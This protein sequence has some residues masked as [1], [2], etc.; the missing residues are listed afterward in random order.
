VQSVVPGGASWRQGD[1][2]AGDLI[3]AVAQEGKE[4][5]DVADMPIDE[6]VQMIRGKKGTVVTLSVRKG[7]GETKTISITRDVVVI[8]D[9]YARG[10]VVTPKGIKASYGYIYLPGF[11]G[12]Q[13][14]GQRGAAS[15]M[16]RLLVELSKRKVDGV[17]IDLRGNG[18]GL[19][20]DAR[21]MTGLLIDKGPVVQTQ[22]GDGE[23]EVLSDDDAGTAFDGPVVVMVDRFSASASEI[24]AGALQDYHRAVIVG[25][26]THGKGT[27]Q[28]LVDLDRMGRAN[29]QPLGVFKLTVQQFFRV[30]GSS[31]QWKGVV[32]DVALPDPVDFL[33]TREN[34]L[35]N[36]LPWSEI[37][38]LPHTDWKA[39]WSAG[40]L[41]AASEARQAKS[42]V[43]ATVKAR[44][45]LLRK[46]TKETEVPLQR[47]AWTALQ[48]SQ[49]DALDALPLDL[50]KGPTRMTATIVDYDGAAAATARPGGRTDDRAAKWRDSLVRDP[51]VE[52]ALRVLHDA[53]AAK[54]VAR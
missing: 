7:T 38:A 8:E 26:G 21:E 51:W 15:D 36:S 6:V 14:L 16:R 39:A 46:R 23:K 40:P 25:T 41:E 2:E 31:T 33:E 49:K 48:K 28:L 9:S 45:E 22:D 3:E 35:D 27:V 12:G 54:A 13:R 5:V 42:K 20:D 30:S 19:L 34:T 18:G 50:D 32:P 29:D 10:A 47:S 24:L 4:A 52:E 1:L 43:F 44:T 37:A 17:V 53:G 11:Y